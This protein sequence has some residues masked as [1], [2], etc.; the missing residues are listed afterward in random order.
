MIGWSLLAIQRIILYYWPK[1]VNLLNFSGDAMST[2][3]WISRIGLILRV[4]VEGL[5]YWWYPGVVMTYYLIFNLYLLLTTILTI[6]T[7]VRSTKT[8]AEYVVWQFALPVLLKLI[9][10][11]V[12]YFLLTI[13]FSA[14]EILV[15]IK[16]LDFYVTLI[17][18]SFS[19][20]FGEP[21]KII[22]GRS[23][24]LAELRSTVGVLN[25]LPLYHPDFPHAE[26]VPKNYGFLHERARM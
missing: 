23:P 8:C 19:L 9:Y 17:I 21:P 25:V 2:V 5:G 7:G 11:P 16:I 22:P 1:R 14:F 10:T 13:Y 12:L 20:G 18:I 3:F 26:T 15:I 4:V 6:S 24:G